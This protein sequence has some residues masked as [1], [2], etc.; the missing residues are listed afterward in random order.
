MQET[1]TESVNFPLVAPQTEETKG[2]PP[3]SICE[4]IHT[5]K[6]ILWLFP[7]NGRKGRK[8][9]MLTYH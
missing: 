1:H 4:S 6:C 8:K 7:H 2:K 3:N 5:Y 9:N